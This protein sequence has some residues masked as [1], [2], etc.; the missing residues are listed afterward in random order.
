M[1]AQYAANCRYCGRPIQAGRDE[2][3]MDTKSS[4]HLECFE[5]QPPSA[6]Q[7]AIAAECSF[8]PHEEA[9]TASWSK[10]R[11]ELSKLGFAVET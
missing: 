8:L 4:Y 11:Q 6:E 10:V 2:Y 7:R 1:I 3:D 9:M 5:N